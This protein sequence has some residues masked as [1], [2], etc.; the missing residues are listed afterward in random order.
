MDQLHRILPTVQKPARYVG[1]EYGQIVKDKSQ[2]DLRV[3]FCFPDTYEIGMSNI[4]MRI[5]YGIMNE[6]DGVWCERVFAPWGDM[7]AAM[8]AHHIPLY[9]LESRDPVKDFDLIA[10][11][12]GYEMSYTNI[13]NMLDLAGVP[14]RS[15]DRPGLEGLVFAGG[16]CTVN[17]EPLADFID[18]FSIGEGEE[19]TPEILNLYRR[20]KAEGWDKPRFLRAVAEIPGVYVPSLYVHRYD[21]AGHLCAIEPLDGAPGRVA[22]R[23]VRDLDKAYYPTHTI[24]PSTEIVHD[25]TNLEVFRGCIRGCRFCQAGFCYRPVR[26]KRPE[27]LYRQAVESLEDSGN[28]E[29]TLSSLS[30]SDYRH[31][32]PL[33]DG[34]LD[35]CEAKRINLSLPSLRADNFSRELML[36]VQRVRK[37]GLTFAPEAGSQRL[38]DA[39]NKNVTEEEILT[40]C[41]TAFSG[42]WNNVKLYFMLGLPTE[43]DEDVL[44]IADLV[45]KIIHT[46]RDHA[47]SKKRG[48]SINLSTAFFV[49]K[50]FTPFQWEA[51]I[52]PEEY[53]RRVHLLKEN[54][55]SRAVD[56][57][58]HSSDLSFL[59]AVL[60][61]G[62]RRLGPVLEYA[63]RHG[64]RLDGWDEYFR[65][66][67]WM[68]AFRACGVD[69]AYYAQRAYGREELLPWETIDVGISKNFF[70]RERERAYRSE[71]SPD[72]RAGCGGCGA[73]KLEGGVICD[74]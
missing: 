47:S 33:A 9:A 43:T 15:E 27:T 3:A 8:R 23:I 18:F 28:H 38:R 16:V 37:S 48:L 11:S 52:T 12:I 34:L 68:D 5:L 54:L 2:V 14:L 35:Y 44:A 65:F 53:L 67:L 30:T 39:I 46:W 50:P 58:Y 4:G 72:C 20:A 32:E 19:M 40:T 36:K 24:V 60:A 62:D 70:W 7:E 66:D 31:L 55:R 45:G 64:A 71:I 1:G 63:V 69:P 57:R 6:M 61:R 26:E 13:L 25:R 73:N 10:F 42:G 51:Q 41:A 56:Y 22:K 17:P 74:V 49:P 29:I 21:A 59:E